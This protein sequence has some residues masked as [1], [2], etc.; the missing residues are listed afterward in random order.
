MLNCP[1]E[2]YHSPIPIEDYGLI[3]EIPNF[4]TPSELKS[5]EQRIQDHGQISPN[6]HP[7]LTLDLDSPAS[8]KTKWVTDNRQDIFDYYEN[9]FPTNYRFSRYNTRS[10]KYTSYERLQGNP[11]SMSGYPPHND[12]GKCITVICPLSP[13]ESISTMFHGFDQKHPITSVPWQINHAILFCPSNNYSFHSYKGSDK[14]RWIFHYNLFDKLGN[15]AP[16]K[17]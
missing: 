4:F 9:V 10:G 5:F 15:T 17:W 12:G 7:C 8:E 16:S 2:I 14:D 13:E 1:F 3:L 11:G 6:V